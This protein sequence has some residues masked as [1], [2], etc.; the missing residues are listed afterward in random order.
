MNP[1]PN[2]R[3]ISGIYD[4]GIMTMEEICNT[5]GYYSTLICVHNRIR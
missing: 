4:F 3:Y 2:I 1:N 5:G